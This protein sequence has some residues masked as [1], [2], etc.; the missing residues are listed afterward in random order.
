VHD[1]SQ[2]ANGA[3]G[4][5]EKIRTKKYDYFSS[6]NIFSSHNISNYATLVINVMIHLNLSGTLY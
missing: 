4:E 2:Y 1:I 6:E 5:G 3:F